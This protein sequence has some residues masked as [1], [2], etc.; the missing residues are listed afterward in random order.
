M[1]IEGEGR[2]EAKASAL[3]VDQDGEFR[4]VGLVETWDV[5]ASRDGGVL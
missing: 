4:K 5:E 1:V 3:E 2:L